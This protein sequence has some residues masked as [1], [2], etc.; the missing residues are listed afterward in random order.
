MCRLMFCVI[1]RCSVASFFPKFPYT[2]NSQVSLSSPFSVPVPWPCRQNSW[3]CPWVR[4][5]LTPGRMVTTIFPS[6]LPVS[7]LPFWVRLWC[8]LFRLKLMPVCYGMPSLNQAYFVSLPQST[9]N[10]KFPMRPNSL[11][12]C[13]NF[14]KHFFLKDRNTCITSSYNQTLVSRPTWRTIWGRGGGMWTS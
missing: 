10:R 5:S 11:P 1:L 3:C 12:S 2:L 9:G 8:T 13:K 4:V 14:L 7:Q 6:P